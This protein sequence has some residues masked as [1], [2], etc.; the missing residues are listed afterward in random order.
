MVKGAVDALDETLQSVL[1]VEAG[2]QWRSTAN[3]D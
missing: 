2:D 3:A 1:F